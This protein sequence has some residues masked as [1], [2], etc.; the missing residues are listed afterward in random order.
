MTRTRVLHYALTAVVMGIV[1]MIQVS[2]ISLLP[3]PSR[4]LQLPLVLMWFLVL[5]IDYPLGLWATAIGG[6]VWEWYSPLPWGS[7]VVP[8]VAVMV[9]ANMLFKAIF[10]NRSLFS[11]VVLTG[12][13]TLVWYVL[14]G[15]WNQML[16]WLG[17]THLAAILDW[18]WW[19]EHGARTVAST[20]GV[21]AV[22]L[23]MRLFTKRGQSVFLIGGRR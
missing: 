10:T 12:G 3:T 6:A 8:L 11:L 13:G 19:Q 21:A 22:F 15:V 2:F 4:W 16:W 5:I 1:V 18:P 7:L 23:V 9:L 17:Y 14:N 20:I